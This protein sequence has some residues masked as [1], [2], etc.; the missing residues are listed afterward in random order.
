MY[1]GRLLS[2]RVE[3][4]QF[5]PDWRPTQDYRTVVSARKELGG[6]ALLELSHEFDYVRW[7]A[8]EVSSVAATVDCISGLDIEVEDCAE[9]TLR[10]ANGA[11][12]QVHLD[13]FQR[14]PTRTC[15][16]LGT[17]G[18]IT[19]DGITNH[20]RRFQSATKAWDDLHPAITLD[21]NEMY[22]AELRHF[23]AC[24]Q[25][26]EQPLITGH[27]GLAALEIA[28]AAKTSAEQQRPQCLQ[29]SA[30]QQQ[31]AA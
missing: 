31:R 27:D 23:F 17:E 12:G 22:L 5:L 29:D 3:T 15:R 9:V 14:A 6:G 4:G 1:I 30:I 7:I 16:V 21:R 19:W 18:T 24:I 11:I 2:I 20:V 28:I 10:F 13:L 26:D 8:G 25:G